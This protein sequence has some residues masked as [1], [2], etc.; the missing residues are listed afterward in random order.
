MF[1]KIPRPHLSTVVRRAASISDVYGGGG[2]GTEGM[3]AR[4][5]CV[6]GVGLCCPEK[7]FGTKALIP[8]AA[9]TVAVGC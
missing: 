6:V 5:P 4:M 2:G 8:P 3:A 7:P 9:R 1:E